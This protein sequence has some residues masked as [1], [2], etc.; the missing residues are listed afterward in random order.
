MEN[1]LKSLAKSALIRLGLTAAA[2][3]KDAAIHK[4]CLDQVQVQQH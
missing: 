1:V 3:A 2:A 4:K